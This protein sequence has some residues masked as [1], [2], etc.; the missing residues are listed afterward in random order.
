MTALPLGAR[1]P[2]DRNAVPRK[3]RLAPNQN[4]VILICP[5]ANGQN[6]R[7]RSLMRLEIP[8]MLSPINPQRRMFLQT[9]GLLGATA[10]ASHTAASH[11]AVNGSAVAGNVI[12]FS[13]SFV[14]WTLDTKLK[15]PKTVSKPL[16]MTLNRVRMPI[17]A[18]AT[19]RHLETNAVVR[20][21][22]GAECRTEQVW[23]K[24][25]IWHDPNAS[26]VM[27]GGE[28]HCLIE[29][30]WARADY[31][32]TLYPP[33][34]GAQPERQLVDPRD[35]FADF[36]L[37]IAT[38][39]GRALETVDSI[40][41]AFTG[42]AAVVARTEYQACGYAIALEYPVKTVNFS[43]RERY[44]QVD[45]GPILFP[46]L[47]G[48]GEGGAPPLAA[49]RL[50]FIAHNA[51]DWAEFLVCVPTPVKDGLRVHHYSKSVRVE[52]LKNQL[53]LVVV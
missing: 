38:A 24:R 4:D 28:K 48:I 22:L 45:T 26:M 12:D 46:G 43:E 49:C 7:K 14:R 13:R 41:A 6:I 30:H 40:L 11:A 35:A 2:S 31:E 42:T 47:E 34:L 44:Y 8:D 27:I 18:T 36:S 10:A 1:S 29:K 53:F 33:K 19:F 39:S 9:A 17:E 52:G 20:Y 5:G 23:V 25:D 37:D 50:A 15:P 32:A 21:A 51:P 3:S 16:P